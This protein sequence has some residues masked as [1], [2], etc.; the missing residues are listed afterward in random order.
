MRIILLGPPGSGKGTQADLIH[1][2]Y[3]FPKISTG[4]LL[5][6]SVKERTPFGRK[7]ESSMNRGELVSDAIVIGIVNERISKDDCKKGYVL[8]GFPRNVPQARELERMDPSRREIAIY[9]QLADQVIIDRLITRRI[10]SDCGEIYSINQNKPSK[11]NECDTCHGPVIQRD[12]D[13]LEVI[14]E[15]L[16]I[17]R[18]KTEP[19]LGFYKTKKVFH[20]INGY[21]K[22]EEIFDRVCT[23][24]DGKLLRPDSME[25]A[26]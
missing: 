1:K 3:G 15:R 11:E 18:E 16:R 19:L 2:K 24:L 10:C 23:V 17:Y 6:Q 4:D 5:R 26:Q 20:K 8:D 14:E 7:A 21:G 12:D 25:V 13:R 9:I 22:I